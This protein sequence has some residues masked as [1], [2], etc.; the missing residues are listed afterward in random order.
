LTAAAE[1]S[2]AVDGIFAAWVTS[3]DG[4]VVLPSD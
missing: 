2:F 4:G 3:S 1:V